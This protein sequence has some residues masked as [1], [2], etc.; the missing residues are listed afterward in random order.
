MKN[1]KRKFIIETVRTEYHT[2]RYVVEAASKEHAQAIFDEPDHEDY[3][4]EACR[5]TEDDP[6]NANEHVTE[7]YSEAEAKAAG[8]SLIP[9]PLA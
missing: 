5:L 4:P 8:L 7:V 3:D 1:K 2:C 6:V 9:D